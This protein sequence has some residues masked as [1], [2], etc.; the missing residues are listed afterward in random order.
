MFDHGL[1]K[2]NNKGNKNLGNKSGKVIMLGMWNSKTRKGRSRICRGGRSGKL[3]ELSLQ[4]LKK[5]VGVEV[6]GRRG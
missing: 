5:A 6:G 2:S 3:W 4:A 1:H